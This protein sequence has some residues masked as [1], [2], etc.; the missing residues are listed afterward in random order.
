MRRSCSP[1]GLLLVVAIGAAAFVP[2]SSAGS[3]AG[4]ACNLRGSWVASTAETNR[5]LRAI[6][7]T[8]TD[9]RATSG[10]LSATFDRATLTV[11]SLGLRLTGRKGATTIKQEL[12]V[13]A[14]APYRVNGGRLAL[15][16]GTY[17]L[18]YV[19]SVVITSSGVTVPLDLPAQRR[20]T[21]PSSVAYSCTPGTLRLRVAAAAGGVTVAF[22]RDRG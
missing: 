21:P 15:G 22:R 3:V 6:N 17:K 14:V 9:V 1:L 13:A 4:Q 10:A 8:T 7:P 5:Y 18:V 12:D 16:R 20:A 19:R 11:G 2:V